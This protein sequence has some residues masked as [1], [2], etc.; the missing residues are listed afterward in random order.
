MSPPRLRGADDG[1]AGELCH[2]TW[3]ELFFDLVLVVAVSALGSRLSKDYSLAGI[4]QFVGLFVPVW[5]AWVGHT[6]YSARFDTDDLIH[7]LAAAAVTLAAAAMAVR[8]PTAL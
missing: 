1:E 6:I 2:A 3:M 8:I 7:R 5:W 4:L